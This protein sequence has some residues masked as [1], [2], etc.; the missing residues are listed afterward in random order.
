MATLRANAEKCRA[1]RD[2]GLN[3]TNL[4][5]EFKRDGIYALVFMSFQRFWGSCFYIRFL[6]RTFE[7]RIS[8]SVSL[9]KKLA[10]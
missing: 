3:L 4:F 10:K 7:K 9:A 8:R 6:S 1:K 5:F 2:H